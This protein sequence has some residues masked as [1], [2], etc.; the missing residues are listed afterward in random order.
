M[1]TFGKDSLEKLATCHPDIQKVMKEAIKQF[2]FK[3][4]YGTRSAVEQM[5]LYKIGRKLVNGKWTVIG[6][7]VTNLDG[8]NKKSNHNYSPSKAIDIAPYPID[9]NDIESFKQMAQIVKNTA[10]RLGVKLQWGGDWKMR[11]YPHFEIA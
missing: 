9:W 8:V 11:D 2:D 7:T 6:K 5:K 4:I 10:L 1:A 3:V